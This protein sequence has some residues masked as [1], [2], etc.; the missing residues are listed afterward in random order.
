MSAT[1]DEYLICESC[2]RKLAH[3]LQT[4][5]LTTFNYK[6]TYFAKCPW[7]DN[8]SNKV[9]IQGKVIVGGTEETRQK[10]VKMLPEGMLFIMERAN[11]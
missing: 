1:I 9:T 4:E 8:L 10:N 2:H 5:Q 11:D 6:N 7:C 3:L